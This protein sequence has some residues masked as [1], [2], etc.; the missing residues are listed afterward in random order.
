MLSSQDIT[1]FCAIADSESLAMAARKLDV[2]PSAITQRLQSIEAK[3]HLQL[4]HRN[5][6]GLSLTDDGE[7]TRAAGQATLN[8]FGATQQ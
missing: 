2:T 5:T 3:L 4:I 8:G 1:L 6:K 7:F